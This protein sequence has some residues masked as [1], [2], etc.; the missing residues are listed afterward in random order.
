MESMKESY[1]KEIKKH[2]KT[3]EVLKKQMEDMRNN[4]QASQSEL[5]ELQDKIKDLQRENASIEKKVEK[6]SEAAA[7][8]ATLKEKLSKSNKWIPTF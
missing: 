4:G 3:I 1:E 5:A 2:L 6:F 7:E 8:A